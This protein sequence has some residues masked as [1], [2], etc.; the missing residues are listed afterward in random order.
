MPRSTAELT[1]MRKLIEEMQS[2]EQKLSEENRALRLA[3]GD[4]LSSE[5]DEKCLGTFLDRLGEMLAQRARGQFDKARREPSMA[6]TGDGMD[7]G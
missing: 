4:G 2:R 5:E 3:T 1:R 6:A 7:G